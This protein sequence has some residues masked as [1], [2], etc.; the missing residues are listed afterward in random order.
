MEIRDQ[1]GL[2]PPQFGTEQLAEQVMIAVPL[3]APVQRNHQQIPALHPFE[4]L[5]GSLPLQD[6]VAQRSAHP[7]ED[8]GAAHER[9]FRVGQVVKQFRAQVVAHETVI[10]GEP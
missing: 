4:K 7:I 10:A 9:H 2:P 1:I 5:S 8:R 6:G 3:T